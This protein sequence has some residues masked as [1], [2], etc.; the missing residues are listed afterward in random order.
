MTLDETAPDFDGIQG[1]IYDN[2]KQK[3]V[4]D[5]NASISSDVSE[6][7]LF[8]WLNTPTPIPT[9]IKTISSYPSDAAHLVTMD[10]SDAVLS[11]ISGD[12]IY[13]YIVA[14]DNGDTLAPPDGQKNCSSQTEASAMSYDI[15]DV[16]P[17]QKFDGIISA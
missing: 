15:P 7:K 16:L 10:V 12:K 8:V 3:I 2:D 6:Y 11:Y 5:W 13:G 4:V 1:I 9:D 17:P 14:C